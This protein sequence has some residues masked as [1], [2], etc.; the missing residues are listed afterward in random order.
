MKTTNY[1]LYPKKQIDRSVAAAA[2]AAAHFEVAPFFINF[3]KKLERRRR[4]NPKKNI[5][6]F[7]KHVRSVGLI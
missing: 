5:D 2:A 6:K 7:G 1:I 3:D 4:K